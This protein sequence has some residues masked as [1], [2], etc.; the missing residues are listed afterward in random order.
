MSKI[1]NKLIRRILITATDA[2]EGHIPSALSILDIVWVLYYI[3]KPSDKFVLSKGHGSLALYA[4]LA[5]KGLIKQSDL[6]SFCSFDGILGGHPDMN[7]VVGVEASTGSLGHGLPIAVGMAM[8]SKIKGDSS[9]IYCL[10]GDGECNEGSIWESALIA[11]HHGLSNLTCI[12]DYNHSTDRAL[13]LDNLACK[14]SSFGWRVFTANGH[15]HKELKR[16]LSPCVQEKPI[17]IIANTIK[18]NGVAV[19][20]N[21][22]EWHHR[23]PTEE[24][25]AH[26]LP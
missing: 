13:S 3:M 20:E 6:D 7:K 16:V 15:S 23:V 1:I 5:E 9:H 21:N 22:P 18:G 4:V 14:F 19:M 12:I 25:L 10:V 8:A 26:I 2:K 11:S 17:V 24:E